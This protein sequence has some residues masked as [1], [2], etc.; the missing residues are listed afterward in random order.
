MMSRRPSPL[1]GAYLFLLLVC[2]PLSA[3]QSL[4]VKVEGSVDSSA[5]ATTGRAT[6]KLT[7]TTEAPLRQ[8]FAIRL[9]LRSGGRTVQ[10]RDHA[11]PVAVMKWEP[12]K[13]VSYELSLFFPL[14]PK[15]VNTVDVL[16]GFLNPED[17]KVRP[18]LSRTRARNGLVQIAKFTFPKIELVPDASNVEVTIAAA[19]ALAKNDAR[20]AWDQLEF[21][22]R[23][24]DDYN[25]KEQLQKALL[26]VGK[27]RP[28]PL[29]FEEDGIVK[30]R[31][32]AERAR[33]LRQTAGRLF[34]RGRLFAAL[35]LLDEV[36]GALQEDAD[37]A[38]LGALNNAR[39]VTKD[40]DGIAETV[41]AI[42]KEQQAEVDQ[43]AAEH[44]A[45]PERL[46]FAVAMASNKTRRP[47]ARELVRTIEFTPELREE[48]A[49]A[50][51]EIERAWL[52]DVPPEERT[53][54]D[55]AMNH[56]SWARTSQRVSHR[57]V[58]IGPEK[59]VNGIPA[60]S[61]LLFDLAYLYQTDLFGR[62]PNPQG[63]R[64]TVYFKEL[65]EFGGG[66]GGGKII[67]I[68]RAKPDDTKRR[69]DGGLF[70]HELAHCVDDT[71]PIYPGFREG[72]ADFAAAFSYHELGQV[73]QSRLAFGNAKRAFLGDYLN[74]DLE[75]WR[76][77][78]YGPSAGFLLHFMQEHGKVGSHYHWERYRKFFRDYRGDAIKDTRT[79][80]LARAFAYH[81]VEAFGEK[82][83]D[84]LI[85]F[86]WPLLPSDLA[87]VREE[88]RHTR[89]AAASAKLDDSLGSPVPR[90]VMATRLKR[91]DANVDDYTDELGVIKD[92]WV[93]GPFKKKGVD[94]DA[95]RFPPEVEID[96]AKRY[97]S[98]NNNPTWRR[99]G[100][101]PVTVDATGWLRFHFSYMDNT[102]IYALTHV[103]VEAE[104]EAWLHVRGDDDVTVFVNDALIGKYNRKYGGHGPWRPNWQTML[105][106][107]ARFKVTLQPGRN[108]VLLKVRN[109]VGDSGCSLAIAKRSGS[110][111]DLETWTTDVQPATKKLTAIDTPDGKK[112]RQVFKVKG[113]SRSAARKL[114]TPVG[115]WTVRN[116][117]LNG[118]STN[119]G[120]EWRKYTVRPGFPK[121]SPSNLA[122][123]PQKATKEL[124][125]FRLTIDLEEK[126]SAP[127]M[128]VTFQGDGLRD[129]LSGW[130]LI[131]N[132]RGDQVQATI[133]RYDRLV[134]QSDLVKYEV[135]DKKPTKLELLYYGKRLTVRLGTQVLFDQNTIRAIP[136][137]TRIGIA[138]WGPKLRITEIELRAPARTR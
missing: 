120:V 59:L 122:W 10:Q 52:K 90:D 68:G 127:K 37:R 77:P 32:Q 24:T 1:L 27:M 96:L 6:V 15:D 132:P 60:D 67:D 36:G 75:Y 29:S 111:L 79:P 46:E 18:P 118:S 93:I 116:K 128:C 107:A 64:V 16:V 99:P 85:K 105:P 20:A 8:P 103:K 5:L 87:T 80:T 40:R 11:P 23:R 58:M 114:D 63:D 50:R 102:A 126:S 78:N 74:R 55:A 89:R 62:V 82:A 81:L 113:S 12:N 48:A 138:T 66:V 72:L 130:T 22:F 54:A 86:R 129:G 134:Y 97:E 35:V 45:E 106:D 71:E 119:R 19:L 21:S 31:I 125:A 30:G 44:K 4:P 42:T 70:Y 117:A 53:E 104:T 25:L 51:R 131:L 57:F 136:D 7:F 65:W 61:L 34:D 76:I 9:E 49:E 100:N 28:A 56:P 43:L 91:E 92:W 69:V 47:I 110:P 135:D 133:E 115:K 17:N 109:R 112:W 94:P 13:P 95:Y 123:L 41:F 121:D 124:D 88:Q 26:K 108:K 2:A 3:Q 33:Y 83:F 14:T 101:K 84:D 38:V 98:I 137:M 39:R 73:A